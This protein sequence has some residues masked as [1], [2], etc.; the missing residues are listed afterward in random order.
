LAR[1]PSGD[2]RGQRLIVATHNPGKLAEMSALLKPYGV[3]AVSAAA[4]G[5]IEPAETGS[6]FEENAEL[7]AKVAAR[8]SGLPALADDSGLVVPALGGKPGIH[9][10]RWAGAAK[11]FA[12]AMGRVQRLL[13]GLKDRRAF[14][15]AVLVLAW[16]DG[17][18]ESFRGE[19]HGTLVFPP[20]GGRGFGYDPIFLPEGG[21]E[22][23]GE[24]QPE[25]KHK[26]SHR[27]KAFAAF[28]KAW[29]GPAS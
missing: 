27:A 3:E 5:L 19:A 8:A 13:G 1:K 26:I 9:S 25:A 18:I 14:F 15:V 6:S 16:P 21:R 29:L 20:R 17:R 22:T 4:L 24:M 11:D 10:A 23:F 7:K 28:A 12:A 2:L